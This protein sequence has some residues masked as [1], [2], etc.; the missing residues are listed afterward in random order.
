MTSSDTITISGSGNTLTVSSP[1]F[2]ED[3]VFTNAST[4]TSLTINAEGGADTIVVNSLGNFSGD[5]IINAGSGGDEITINAL[6]GSFNDTLT[7]N[8]EDGDDTI[9]VSA[10]TSVASYVLRGGDAGTDTGTADEITATVNDASNISL[11]DTQLVVGAETI[12]ITGFDDAE[13]TAT[14]D[15]NNKFTIAG[16]TGTSSVTTATA[17][18]GSFSEPARTTISA[19]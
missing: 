19:R 13:L 17:T 1:S 8:G 3:F 9:N 18:T 11:S 6:G 14:G 10:V 16:W 7:V 5:L 12:D 4:V 2:A 15:F